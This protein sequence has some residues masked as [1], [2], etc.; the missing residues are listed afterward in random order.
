MSRF[1]ITTMPATGHVMPM[2]P[3]ARELSARGHELHWYAG[4]EYRDRVLSVGASHHPIRSAEDFGG[5]TILEAF[6]ELVGLTGVRMVRKA[7]E[8]VF[9]DNAAGCSARTAWQSRSIPAALSMNT[10]CNAL[11]TIFTPV[12][13]TSSG[14]ASGIVIP[15]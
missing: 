15:P 8:R 3:L 2:L 9:I 4:A 6:P 10:R 5:M 7:F 13:P 11:R 1:L 12:S 14:N